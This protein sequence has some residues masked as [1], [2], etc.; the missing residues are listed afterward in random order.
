M[1]VSSYSSCSDW[2]HHRQYR[3]KAQSFKAYDFCPERASGRAK[4]EVTSTEAS[5]ELD[6]RAAVAAGL[7]Q[8]SRILGQGVQF[9]VSNHLV[10]VSWK[11]G[12]SWLR[13][14]SKFQSSSLYRE[15]TSPSL[16]TSCTDGTH[17]RMSSHM[18]SAT[19]PTNFTRGFGWSVLAQSCLQLWGRPYSGTGNE[20]CSGRC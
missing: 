18:M 6:L 15:S 17:G 14:C 4:A 13:G 16:A 7:S 8:Y 9:K 11:L 5:S 10:R 2:Q 12:L 3:N 19:P 20:A 1:Q